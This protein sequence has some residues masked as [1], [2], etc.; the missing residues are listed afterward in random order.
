MN[1][2]STINRSYLKPLGIGFLVCYRANTTFVQTAF[3][4][5]LMDIYNH[6]AKGD[7]KYYRESREKMFGSTLEDVSLT[8]NM[9]SQQASQMR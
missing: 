1:V 8:C 3:P 2:L 6:L 4:V 7:L 9:P 5:V